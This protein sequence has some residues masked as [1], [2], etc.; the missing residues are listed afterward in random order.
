MAV[1]QYRIF[2]YDIN[3]NTLL[4]ELPGNG[5]TFDTR[6]NDPGSCSFSLNLKSPGTAKRV[7]PIMG[8]EGNPFKVYIDRG[9]VIV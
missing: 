8:Y 6:L 4:C 9:G 3:T 1:E 7:A 2:A 5:L